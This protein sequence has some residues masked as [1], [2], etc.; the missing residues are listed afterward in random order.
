MTQTAEMTALKG[1]TLSGLGSAVA[2]SGD[3]IVA[4]APRY[5]EFDGATYIF[6]Q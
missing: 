3:A 5:N 1:E 4:I 2:V 6:E